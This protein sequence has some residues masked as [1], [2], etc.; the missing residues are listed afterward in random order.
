[1]FVNRAD[2]LVLLVDVVAD[3]LGGFGQGV[4]VD[5]LQAVVLVVCFFVGGDA[6]VGCVEGALEGG[7]GG[8]GGVGGS[9][10]GLFV[11]TLLLALQG[12]GRCCASSQAREMR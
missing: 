11:T 9:C 5:G 7:Y 3:A 4:F 8:C 2:V 1:M 12:R 10:E 6:V